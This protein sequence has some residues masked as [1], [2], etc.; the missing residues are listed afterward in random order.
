MFPADAALYGIT[1]TERGHRDSRMA[2]VMSG[3]W[4]RLTWQGRGNLY[5]S[6]SVFT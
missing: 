5:E 1:R 4:V 2:A 3:A 6:L